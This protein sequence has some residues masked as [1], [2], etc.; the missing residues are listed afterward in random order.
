[1]AKEGL[2]ESHDD[3]AELMRGFEGMHL[4]RSALD[5][6]DDMRLAAVHPESPAFSLGIRACMTGFAW[7]HAVSLLDECEKSSV[8]IDE[9][10]FV[11]TMRATSSTSQW[12]RIPLQILADLCD[13]PKTWDD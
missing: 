8:G 2:L 9:T 5:V 11:N 1:M 10:M 3:Y 4:W 7:Q 6:M 12:T 13:Y